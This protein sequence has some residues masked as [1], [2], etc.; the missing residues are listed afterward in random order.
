VKCQAQFPGLDFG[1]CIEYE[2]VPGGPSDLQQPWVP[3]CYY[4]PSS[5]APEDTK[6]GYAVGPCAYSPLGFPL[7]VRTWVW[8]SHAFSDGTVGRHT[9]WVAPVGCCPLV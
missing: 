8:Y 2:T 1:I 5:G 3:G 7:R 6:D 9:P 4:N